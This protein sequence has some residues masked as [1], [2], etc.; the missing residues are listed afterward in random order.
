MLFCDFGFAH[1]TEIYS[2]QENDPKF[3]KTGK[4]DRGSNGGIVT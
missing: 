1:K 3:W 4:L 2:V